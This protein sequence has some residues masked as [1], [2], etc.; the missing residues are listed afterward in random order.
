MKNI[1]YLVL[2]GFAI[3]TFNACHS[4]NHQTA[5]SPADKP[6]VVSH[7]DTLAI[8][9]LVQQF[10]NYAVEKNYAEA[11]AML[12]EIDD[13]D[14]NQEPILLNNEKM[15]SVRIALSKFPIDGYEINKMTLKEA[16]DNNVEC[17][18]H[19]FGT[20][21]T[22]WYFKPVRYLGEWRLCM[23]NSLTGDKPISE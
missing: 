7:T 19:F 13:N 23:L 12:Y 3:M 11:A 6:M 9:Q 4:D 14:I 2:V 5:D 16:K 10:M 1:I 18:I 17:T 20:A 22:K 21:T 8:H 15:E